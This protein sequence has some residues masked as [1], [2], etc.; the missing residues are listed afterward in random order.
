MGLAVVVGSIGDLFLSIGMKVIGDASGLNSRT[1]W[2]FIWKVMSSPTIW[3]GTSFL[4]VFFF[5][6]LYV[7]SWEQLSVALP[8]QAVIFVLVPLLAQ[9]YLGEGFSVLRWA[10]TILI[11]LG[12][13]MVTIKS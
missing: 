6:W 4:A 13:V 3:I 11:S 5:L 1:I 12:V 9:I 2:P 7:L 10:G 8:M